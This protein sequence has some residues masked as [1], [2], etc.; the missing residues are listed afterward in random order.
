M[1][2]KKDKVY[3]SEIDQ[4]SKNKLFKKESI[5]LDS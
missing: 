4:F 3:A 1:L 2:I 5:E